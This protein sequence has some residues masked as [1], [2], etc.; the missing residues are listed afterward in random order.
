MTRSRGNGSGEIVGLGSNGPAL[1]GVVLRMLR[2]M[3]V[4]LIP[5]KTIV[6]KVNINRKWVAIELRD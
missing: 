5:L 6:N 4:A 1:I 2:T 3:F